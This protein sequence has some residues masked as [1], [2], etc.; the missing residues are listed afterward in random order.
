M[1]A[2]LYQELSKV[3]TM[4]NAIRWVFC[5][6]EYIGFFAVGD[7]YF[8][9]II[10]GRR[11][12]F[13]KL[14]PLNIKDFR[15]LFAIARNRIRCNFLVFYTRAC[16]QNSINIQSRRKKSSYSKND[17]FHSDI[18]MWLR[19]HYNIYNLSNTIPMTNNFFK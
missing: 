14:T 5:A 7:G 15:F 12:V 13:I 17:F 16:Y 9:L 6:V 2:F 8:S 18:L 3:C 10:S 4:I 11:D 1:S 19:L